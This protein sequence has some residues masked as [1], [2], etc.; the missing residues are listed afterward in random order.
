ML[1]RVE[2]FRQV[3]RDK[4]SPVGWFLSVEAVGD[5]CRDVTKSGD[6]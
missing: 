3:N 4:Q 5:G 1:N 2:D 6:R